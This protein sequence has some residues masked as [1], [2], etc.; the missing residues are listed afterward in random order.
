MLLLIKKKACES[1]VKK[2]ISKKYNLSH[3]LI[4]TNILNKLNSQAFKKFHCNCINFKV[5]L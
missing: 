4:L 5:N 2:L 3:R 1:L